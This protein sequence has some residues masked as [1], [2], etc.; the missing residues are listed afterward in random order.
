MVIILP[1]IFLPIYQVVEK[2]LDFANVVVYIKKCDF[3]NVDVAQLDRTI[4][5]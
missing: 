3:G 4:A 5:F 1:Y 2:V